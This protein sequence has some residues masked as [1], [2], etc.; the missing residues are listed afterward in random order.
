MEAIRSLRVWGMTGRLV[1]TD[2]RHM[3]TAWRALEAEITAMGAACDRF[4]PDSELSRVNAAEGRAVRVS[5]LFAETLGHALEVAGATG[6]TVDPTV[7][8]ALVSAGYDRDLAEVRRRVRAPYA[9][10]RPVAGWPVVELADQVV[11]VPRGVMLDLGATA[12]AFAADRAASRAASATG[13]GVLVGLGGDIAVSGPVRPGGWR[14][15][16]SD[17]HRAGP[18]E[19]GQAVTITEGGLATSS[20]TVRRWRRGGRWLHHIMDPATGA[21]AGSHWRTVSVA[22]ASCLDANAAATAAMVKGR[23]ADDWLADRALPARLV[24]LDGTV[25]TVAGWPFDEPPGALG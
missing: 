11:R 24:R 25:V 9:A 18:S 16:V 17:D 22:A 23:G 8:G 20:S 7:G 1:L 10:P 4:R 12:K 2:A 19:P 15:R 6:G 13:C 5:A 21:P 3:E 14:I